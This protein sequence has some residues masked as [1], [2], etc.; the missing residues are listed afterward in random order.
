[1]LHSSKKTTPMEENKLFGLINLR[2]IRFVLVG[3]LNTIFGYGLYCIFIYFGL[4]TEVAVLLST[5]LGVLFNFKTTGSFVFKNK[6]NRLIFR[7]IASYVL[8][9]FVNV[10]II[11][12]LSNTTSLNRYYAGFIATVVVAGLSF[13]IQSNFV[14]NSNKKI[15]EK[16]D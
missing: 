14:F 12:F 13:I 6:D 4:A 7:F 2:L 15:R 10:G 3:V 8:T 1:L 11:W 5:V 16:E 9:Y